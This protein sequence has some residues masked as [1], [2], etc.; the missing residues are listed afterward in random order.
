[1]ISNS[2][3][4]D[5]H[6]NEIV[7]PKFGTA[8]ILNRKAAPKSKN[9]R[10]IIADDNCLFHAFLFCLTSSKQHHLT[11]RRI[12]C[13]YM[14]FYL[15]TWQP[16]VGTRTIS[17]YLDRGMRTSSICREHWGTKIEILT[18]ANMC[19]C[20]VYV[21]NNHNSARNIKQYKGYRPQPRANR[22]ATSIAD[23]T[24]FLLY[25][26]HNHFKVVLSP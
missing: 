3:P 7:H 9:I 21:Y 16:L 14:E 12:I 19:N 5:V 2:S 4:L 24:T 6:R 8:C 23:L 25:N 15:A 22:P 10:K 20:M 26:A 17:E 13:V 1:M 11:I 18:F